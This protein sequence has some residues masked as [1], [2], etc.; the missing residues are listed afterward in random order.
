MY[1]KKIEIIILDDHPLVHEGIQ[2][3]LQQHSEI[4][5]LGSFINA[6]DALNFLKE[7]SA[8]LILLD[9]NLPDI[10]GIELCKTIKQLYHGIKIIALSNHNER[11]IIAKILQNGASGY[12]LKNASSKE[13][14]QAIKD[15]MDGKLILN[16]EVQKILATAN[17]E[18]AEAPHITRREKEILQCIAQ[19]L[20]TAQIAEKL[21]ISPLTVETH[22]R[23]L[24]QKFEVNNAPALIHIA[25]ELK[26]I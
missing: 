2:H 25:V 5:V 13:L 10:N 15:A 17:N 26:M 4:E 24:M 3:I 12:V 18:I 19:G 7:N 16:D 6:E 20:T 1:S 11:L 8:D 23:N 21:F 14:I 22:R 9:I